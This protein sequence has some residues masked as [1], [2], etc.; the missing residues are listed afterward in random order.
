LL[1]AVSR[2]CARSAGEA[3]KEVRSLL[4]IGAPFSPHRT[5]SGGI[6]ASEEPAKT[7]RLRGRRCWTSIVPGIALSSKRS[8]RNVKRGLDERIQQDE[9]LR[10]EKL[11]DN[12]RHGKRPG[13]GNSSRL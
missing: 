13:D 7:A 10:K 6:S 1:Q 5:F 9:V 3:G 4:A 11:W 12:T 8:N 2:A